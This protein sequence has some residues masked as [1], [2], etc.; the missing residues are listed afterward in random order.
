VVALFSVD[1]MIFAGLATPDQ[2]GAYALFAL[3]CASVQGLFETAVLTSYWPP[4]LQAGQDGDH[5]AARE[6]QRR[7]ARICLLGAMG[8]GAVMAGG[9]TVLAWLLPHPAY[10]ANLHLLFYMV[11]AYAFLALTNIPHYR[12]YAARRDTLIVTADVAALAT[13]LALSALIMT[14]DRLLAVPLAL[15]IACASLLI[16]KSVMAHRPIGR[17][18][19]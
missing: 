8:G 11:A 17:V 10:W 3:G 14:Y 9:L 18:R 1:K 16:I 19:A 7:L 12:L 2:L 4:L 6:A 13:F 15:T 5:A